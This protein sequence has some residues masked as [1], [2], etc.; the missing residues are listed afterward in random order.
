MLFELAIVLGEAL[1][2]GETPVNWETCLDKARSRQQRYFDA[3]EPKELKPADRK[4]ALLVANNLYAMLTTISASQDSVILAQPR[5]PGYRWIASGAGDFATNNSIIE[6]KCSGKRF[7]T[8]DYRQ[9]VIYWLLA[10]IKGLESNLTT[11]ATGIL[12]NPRLCFAVRFDFGDLIQ[13]IAARRS[14]V[15]IVESFGAIFDDSWTRQSADAS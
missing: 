5:I 4:V 12:L 1:L 14:P 6:V 11:W 13:V 9:I 3:Q 10:Y 15:E 7:S 2:L 8:A